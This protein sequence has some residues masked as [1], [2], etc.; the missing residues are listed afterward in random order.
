[1][2]HD[3]NLTR[4]HRLS[5]FDYSTPGYYFVTVCTHQRQPLF[6]QI[7]KGSHKLSAAGTVVMEV[8]SELPQTFTGVVVESFI[9]MPNHLH[10]L[11]YLDIDTKTGSITDVVR[12]IKGVTTSRY[13]KGVKSNLWPAYQGHFWQKGFND[14]IIRNENHLYQVQTYI[15]NNPLKWELDELYG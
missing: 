9:V 8:V 13:G 1:M 4:R 3:H 7:L 15:E 14:Q 11:I 10:L 12:W 6:G 5:G 2:P